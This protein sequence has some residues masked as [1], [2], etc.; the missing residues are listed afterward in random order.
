M[1][2]RSTEKVKP[3]AKEWASSLQPHLAEFGRNIGPQVNA[4]MSTLGD[5]LGVV[6]PLIGELA[7]A[8]GNVPFPVYAGGIMALIA[9]HKGWNDSL[10]AGGGV[11]KAFAGKIGDMAAGELPLGKAAMDGLKGAGEGLLGF[12]GGPW[13]L[14][15]GVAAG[16]VTLLW[17]EHQKAKVAEEEHKRA[18]EQLRDTLDETTGKITEQ[19]NELV[20]GNMQESGALDVARDLGLAH[21]LVADAALGNK[22]AQQEVQAAIELSGRKALASSD[23][24]NKFKDDFAAVG[25][26]ADEVWKAING[27]GEIMGEINRAVG[28]DGTGFVKE[29]IAIQKEIEGTTDGLELLSDSVFGTS[30]DLNDLQ[31][32]ELE[33]KLNSLA[34]QSDATAGALEL[35]GDSIIAIPDEKT[36]HLSSLAPEV[37]KELEELGVEVERMP[38][39]EVKLHFKDGIAITE[40]IRGIGGEMQLLENGQVRLE[41]NTPEV[42]ARLEELGMTT[43]ING[44]LFL[45]DNLSEVIEKEVELEAAVVDPKTGSV[46]VN[47]N[48]DEVIASLDALGIEA[49]MIPSGHVRITDDTPQTRSALS[50]LGIE[51]TSLPGGHVADRKSVV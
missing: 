34:R 2:F 18:Q 25:F 49:S 13:G 31:A 14:A 29:M 35:V 39:G 43:E 40:M 7:S 6:G 50:S 51:T 28:P 30:K 3:A 27:D 20:R 37:R 32:E 12:F 44:E 26:T 9:N 4:A 33:N 36:I 1:L 8:M 17:Q 11:L 19:T 47:D 22:S 5:T 24:W 46:Y 48:V 41:D 45:K 10:E 23:N 42:K 16:A 21:S 38:N 15:I